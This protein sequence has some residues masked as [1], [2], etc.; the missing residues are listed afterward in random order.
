MLTSLD[1]KNGW[2]RPDVAFDNHCAVDLGGRE[3]ELYR[4]GPGNGPGDVIVYEPQTKTAWTGNFLPRAGVGP[5]LLEGGPGPYI[6]SLQKMR[7]TVDV[8]TVVAGHAPMGDG[9]DAIDTMIGY[10]RELQDSVS[11]AIR[12]G[13]TLEDTVESVPL[14]D[15]FAHPD[16]PAPADK[17]LAQLNQ[18]MH[19]LNI[20]STYR[21]LEQTGG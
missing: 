14:P 7:D 16:L 13:Q 15:R 2:R 20:V 18:Q 10:W 9:R 17:L 8:K 21:A 11:E 6:E 4:F 3:V 12:D 5:M 19:R 1:G